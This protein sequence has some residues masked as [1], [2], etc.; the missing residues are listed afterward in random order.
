[1]SNG[2]SDVTLH[3][4]SAPAAGSTFKTAADGTGGT[5]VYDPPGA[6][7]MRSLHSMVQAMATMTTSAA[8]SMTPTGAAAPQEAHTLAAA[9]A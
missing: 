3:L 1:M 2:T 7:G 8:P 9:H 5:L 6:A 4:A